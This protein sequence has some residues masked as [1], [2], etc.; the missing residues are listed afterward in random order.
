[1]LASLPSVVIGRSFGCSLAASGNVTI[2]VDAGGSLVDGEHNIQQFGKSLCQ[3]SI[4]DLV[5]SLPTFRYGD[6]EPAPP[7]AGQVVGD[8]RTSE[9]E[10]GSKL[11]GV[12]RAIK[13]AHQDAGPVRI[14]HRAAK[15]VHDVKLGRVGQ[16]VLTI[17]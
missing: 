1:M 6:H 16:H 4:G 5:T 7:E 10:F 2:A 15:P 13:K 9:I 11:P 14:C 17:Q 8:V 3:V 12:S